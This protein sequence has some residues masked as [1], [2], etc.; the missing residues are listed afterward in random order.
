MYKFRNVSESTSKSMRGNKGTETKTEILLRKSLWKEGVRGYRKN[1]KK[2]L[3]KPDIFFPN[4]KLVVF[5]NGCFWHRCPYCKPKPPKTNIK[6]WKEKFNNNVERDK[7]IQT[8]LSKE[9]YNVTVVWECQ[10]K[11]DLQKQVLKII[12]KL[13]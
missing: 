7:R 13:K 12:K 6:F 5:V 11:K 4:K 3:G 10:L 9:G 2:L 1:Y 8:T